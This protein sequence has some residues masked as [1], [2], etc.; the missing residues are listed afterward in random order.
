MLWALCLAGR[1]LMYEEGKIHMLEWIKRHKVFVIICF[2]IIV[3]GVPFAIHCLFKIH[4]TEDYDFFVDVWSAGE[5]LQ[6]YGGVLAFSGTVILGALSLHQNEIIKQESD[7]RIAIQEKREHDSN[8]PR[9]RVKF[10]CCNG[11]YSNM[12]VKIENIS[13]NVANEILVYKICVVKDKNVIWKYPNAVK[14]DVIKANDELEVELKTE[15][16]QEDKVSIQFDFRCNDK[17]GEEHKYHVYSFCESNS[18]TP[19]FSI[20][21]IFEE[22]P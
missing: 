8:I 18:S 16:I 6:Y 19:Y 15:E 4:P 20:K 11:R 9:F 1:L 13:D 2:V 5:L 22:N 14:Y 3:I 12:K 7:K 21:E 10:L 17:Y